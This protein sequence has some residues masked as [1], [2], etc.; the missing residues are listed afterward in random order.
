MTYIHGLSKWPDL[1][2]DH[3]KLEPILALVRK[4]EGFLLGRM[5]VLG[6]DIQNEANLQI[7]TADVIKSS[8]IEGEI[9]N[10]DEVRS[11]L[12]KKLGM[13]FAGLP[14]ASRHVDGIVE[15]ML[16]ATQSYQSPL[17]KERLFGWHNALFPT[18][19]SGCDA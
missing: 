8:A 18:G 10:M 19:R 3:S 11:S 15:M 6:F 9:L 2:W 14:A 13:E 5:S 16:D 7:L 17:T 12:A 4:Q 1:L